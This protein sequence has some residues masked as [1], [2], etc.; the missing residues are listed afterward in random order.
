MQN[1]LYKFKI[2]CKKCNHDDKTTLLAIESGL[3]NVSPSIIIRCERCNEE[4]D[5]G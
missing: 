4:E 5:N 2:V 3:E 1:N